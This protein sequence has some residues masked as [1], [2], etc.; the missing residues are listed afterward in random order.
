MTLRE[1]QSLFAR[2]VPRLIDHIFESGYECTYGE[3]WRPPQMVEIY[4]ALGTGSANS[5]HPDRLA[6]DINLFLS[7]KLLRASEAHRPFGEW[8][9]RLHPLARWGGRFVDDRGRPTPDGN[10]YSFTYGGRK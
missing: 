6:I 2:H 1:T 5:L 8:W 9:E 3:L 7:G 10:H 4:V